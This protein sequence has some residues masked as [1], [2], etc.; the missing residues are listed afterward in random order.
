MARLGVEP[1]FLGYEPSVTPV[2]L[3]ATEILHLAMNSMVSLFSSIINAFSNVKYLITII[4]SC[5]KT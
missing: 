4:F 5:C 2:H 3:P 1:N